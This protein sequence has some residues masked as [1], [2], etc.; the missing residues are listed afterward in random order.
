MKKSLTLFA[1]VV[2][3]AFAPLTTF[4]QSTAYQWDLG[5][6]AGLYTHDPA[7][8]SSDFTFIGPGP[9][10]SGP[11][12]EYDI[13]AI[14]A[15]SAGNLWAV[16]LNVIDAIGTI[17]PVDA[18][19]TTAGTLTGD[20]PPAVVAMTI[21]TTSDIAYVSDGDGLWTID[22][23]TFVCTQV[24]A[25]FTNTAGGA[26]VTE[27]FE[28]ATDSAGNFWAF[29]IT[30]DTLWDL[31]E[32]TGDV[33]AINVYAGPPGR[34]GP[35]FSNNGMDWD[36]VSG[37]LLADVYT[38]GGTGSYG[39][40]NTT[41][42]VFTEILNHDSFPS[43]TMLHGGPIA[44]VGGTTF[45]IDFWNDG[46]QQYDTD[47]PTMNYV[48]LA[49]PTA[50]ERIPAVFAT[51]FN[52]DGS[53]LYGIDQIDGATGTYDLLEIDQADP[54]VLT[55]LTS[56]TGDLTGTVTDMSYD[57]ANDIWYVQNVGSLFILDIDTGVTTLA[58]DY[59]SNVPLDPAPAIPVGLAVDSAGNMFMFS[60]GDDTLWSV[61]PSTG[62][63]TALGTNP[64]LTDNNFIQGMD[65]D[66][67]TD[68]LY[69]SAFDNTAGGSYGSWDTTTGIFTEIE[70]L[71][72][73][74]GSTPSDFYEMN[75]AIKALS[76]PQTISPDTL[77]VTA[78]N[79][80]TGGLA[81]LL[82]NDSADL[83]IFRSPQS[84]TPRTEFVISGTSQT[85][86]PTTFDVT[87][88]GSCFARTAV[89]QSIALFNF[90][91]NS[92]DVVSSTNASLFFD[93]SVSASATGTL[94]DYVGPGNE[95]RA[96]VRFQGG[97]PRLVFTSNTDQ[98]FW[99]VE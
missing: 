93:N 57:S 79:L 81:E 10:A 39:S 44:C 53:I 3:C 45:Q 86:T 64:A 61:D 59:I 78:G 48:F 25:Q 28:L 19:F 40:W 80:N 91:T 66:P 8:P 90:T 98:F 35:N 17:N 49:Q 82:E 14:D 34:D 2:A 76:G 36:P 94:S 42:G 29:D 11:E 51:E 26:A 33:T 83:S 21:D 27:V 6:D 5:G 55:V 32:T 43:P 13:I 60:S 69:H 84:V 65:F 23:G 50:S 46:Y 99:T 38:G 47:D 74:G 4:A 75:L 96:R 12:D 97:I 7:N 56:I 37:Q 85:A 52:D 63:C 72:T 31:D 67:A 30:L 77:T 54:S 24:A 70:P 16:D 62:A 87:L 15:D 68:I 1:A 88:E 92:Y 41:T 9:A 89:T 73:L 71:Q 20:V 22:L 95:I 58:A 18:E